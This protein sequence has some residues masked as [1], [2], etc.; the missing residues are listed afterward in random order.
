MTISQRSLPGVRRSFSEVTLLVDPPAGGPPAGDARSV[1]LLRRARALGVTTFDVT[2]ARFPSRA[3]RLI[4]TAFPDPDSELSVIVGRSVT[5]LA[6]ERPPV[7]G[8]EESWDFEHA[9]TRSLEQSSRRLAPVAISLVEWDPA[10]PAESTDREEMLAAPERTALPRDIR[11]VVR[12]PPGVRSLPT[13]GI[14]TPLFSGPLSPLEQGLVAAFE[15]GSERSEARLVARDPFARGRLD[16]SRFARA[17]RFAGPGT[18][19]I[20]L[21]SLHEEFDPLL[22]FGFLTEG[23]R[24]TLAQAA[25]QFALSFGWVVTAVVPLPDPERLDELLGAGSRPLLSHDDL[26][27]LTSMK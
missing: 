2:D 7:R 19:P 10:H 17:G 14:G 4:A 25:L 18:A 26:E 21:R 11:W 12:L 24:R 23:R 6:E 9:L 5:S 1:A 22:R 15:S 16:G 8:G 27:R 20:N 13:G 3:E